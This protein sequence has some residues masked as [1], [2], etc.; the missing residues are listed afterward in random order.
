MHFS[1]EENLFLSCKYNALVNKNRH[2]V[3][4]WLLNLKVKTTT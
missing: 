1:G 3:A 4:P 2:G